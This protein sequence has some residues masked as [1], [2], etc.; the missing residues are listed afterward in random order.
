MDGAMNRELLAG[1]GEADITPDRS[2]VELSGQYYQRLSQ[3]IH[4]RLKTVAL[5]LSQGAERTVLVSLDCVGVPEDFCLRLERAIAGRSPGLAGARLIVNAT[6]THTAPSLTPTFEWSAPPPG[7]L[8]C[9]EH[10]DAVEAKVL[11]AVGAAWNARQPAGI[12]HVLES[13]RLGHCRRSVYAGGT[14]EMYGRTDREDFAGMEGGE[15]SGVELLFFFDRQ[16]RP[17]GAIV[18]AACPSQVMEATCLIS[19]DFMGALREKLKAEYG[20]GFHTLCQIGAAGDQ[21][22]RDL[23]RN[24]K[25]EPDF[26]HADGVDVLAD[27]LLAAVR[28]GAPRAAGAID[29]APVL[30][31]TVTG[32]ALPKRRVADLQYEAARK[33]LARL[34]AIQDSAAAFRDFCATVHRNEKIP[35]RP[36]P[37]DN[38]LEH[39]VLMRNA[40][41][42]VRRY[43]EQNR[44][45]DVAMRLHVVRLGGAAIAANPFELYLEFGQRIKARSRAEQTFVVQLANGIGGYLPTRRAEELGGYGGLV[46]NGQVGSDGGAKLVDETVAAIAALWR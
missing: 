1:W 5:V 24:Y 4:S 28:R 10:R 19:S 36:G 6:H 33:E 30:A 7:A 34:E 43:E 21:S 13:A 42:V 8:A 31:H 39:F 14:A 23:A 9:E 35:G 22:P 17:L 38:K 11:Q 18:N 25:G 15:D 20:A 3:G 2:A 40:E 29:A 16:R 44:A 12:A 45:P 46:I 26:W 41:A 27:R 32:I 37:Y